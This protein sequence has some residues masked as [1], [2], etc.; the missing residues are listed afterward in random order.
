MLP[1]IH[2]KTQVNYTEKDYLKVMLND[3]DKLT[4]TIT[5][6]VNTYYRL[7]EKTDNKDKFI[8]SNIALVVR[9]IDKCIYKFM[10]KH[11]DCRVYLKKVT[12]MNNIMLTKTSDKIKLKFINYFN[13]MYK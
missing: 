3:Y 9:S 1:I 6:F 13:L 5:Q 7:M 8:K 12:R 4:I 11:D 10:Q 2:E